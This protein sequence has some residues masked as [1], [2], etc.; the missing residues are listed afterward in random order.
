MIRFAE[1]TD[2]NALAALDEHVSPDELKRIIE[3]RRVL[4]AESNETIVGWLR[5]GLFWDNLPF[6]NML[7]IVD[8]ERGKRYGTALCDL[9]ENDMRT[10]G[11]DLVLTSTLSNEQAQHFY[12][13]RGYKDC[14]SLILLNEP[15][16]IILRKNLN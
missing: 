15:L 8:K 7:Y 16:E 1:K 3:C 12:R 10:A 11:F 2:L 9:W 6:M 14:G 4:I 13:K 5:F